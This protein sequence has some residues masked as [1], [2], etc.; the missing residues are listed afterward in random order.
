MKVAVAGMEDVSDGEIEVARDLLDAL[1][2]GGELRAWDDGVVK[3]VIRSQA[4]HGPKGHLASF[5]EQV[6]FGLFGGNA[7]LSRARLAADGGDLLAG[8]EDIVSHPVDLNE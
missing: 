8:T 1:E 7:N 2:R 4:A 3:V 5:P 6:P